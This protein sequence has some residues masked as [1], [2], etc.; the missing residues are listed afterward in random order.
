MRKNYLTLE[1]PQK[2]SGYSTLVTFSLFARGSHNPYYGSQKQ[3]LPTKRHMTDR[4]L[5]YLSEFDK[6]AHLVTAHYFD[7]ESEARVAF[8]RL[9]EAGIPSAIHHSLIAQTL[10]L[11]T[12]TIRLYVLEKDLS[13]A[14]RLLAEME[15]NKAL[16]P[17]RFYADPDEDD[18]RFLS[19]LK[20]V[21]Q[22]SRFFWVTLGIMLMIFVILRML[23]SYSLFMT[24]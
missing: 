13:D 3:V 15:H 4:I 12:G 16:N 23:Y 2:I 20:Q 9:R 7:L 17:H 22:R 14:C 6:D 1:T 24:V 18:I 11:G 19:E 5:D 10:P 8:A 21:K